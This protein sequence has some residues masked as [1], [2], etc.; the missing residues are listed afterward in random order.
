MFCFGTQNRAKMLLECLMLCTL[1]KGGRF[2]R[3]GT[4]VY[5]WLTHGD[6]RNQYN[7]V[8]QLSSN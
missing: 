6:G 2:K 4:Y 8:K 1:S 7:I 3:K 5:L